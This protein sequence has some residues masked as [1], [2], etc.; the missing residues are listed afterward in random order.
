MINVFVGGLLAIAGGAL[1][2]F[3]NANFQRQA[4]AAKEC[5]QRLRVAID[6]RNRAYYELISFL[7]QFL[8]YLHPSVEKSEDG[9]YTAGLPL[10]EH[11]KTF[12]HVSAGVQLYG[13]EDVVKMTQSLFNSY[14]EIPE[15]LH[16]IDKTKF[17]ELNALSA[18]LTAQMR[19][20]IEAD[21]KKGL[22]AKCSNNAPS[23]KS[24]LASTLKEWSNVLIAIATVIACCI[25]GCELLSGGKTWREVAEMFMSAERPVIC[26]E[27]APS[28]AADGKNFDHEDCRILNLGAL[29]R[30]YRVRDIKEYLVMNFTGSP[31]PHWLRKVVV[32]IQF[33][34]YGVSTQGLKDVIYEKKGEC[35]RLK[36]FEH[37]KR[38]QD[39][40]ASHGIGYSDSVDILAYVSYV[41]RFGR[42][43]ECYYK[44]DSVGGQR[45]LTK[46]EYEQYAVDAEAYIEN[47][48]PL[49]F[50]KIDLDSVL[51]NWVL[52][53]CPIKKSMIGALET[54]SITT[55]RKDM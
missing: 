47:P 48:V 34:R 22:K 14:N 24:S 5:A 32:P 35:A 53:E 10:V 36:A 11:V 29:P 44:C 52:P 16:E 31:V 49:E 50:E 54:R 51:N 28:L 6:N 20:E 37:Y 3:I 40:F 33:Y 15:K 8:Q 26:V 46:D 1:A 43:V 12:A 41:D 21:V 4:M 30:Y 55:I 17:D 38:A 18:G 13:S 9:K 2:S 19:S 23:D 7:G 39:F 42:E 25:A 45:E 27:R